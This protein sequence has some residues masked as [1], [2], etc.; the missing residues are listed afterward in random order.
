M[1]LENDDELMLINI[2]GSFQSLFYYYQKYV[3]DIMEMDEW[4]N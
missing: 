2:L 1:F 4:E 3:D